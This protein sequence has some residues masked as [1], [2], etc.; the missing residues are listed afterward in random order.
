MGGI[1]KIYPLLPDQIKTF[2]QISNSKVS[3]F[4]V[5]SLDPLAVDNEQTTFVEPQKQVAAGYYY[6]AKLDTFYNKDNHE[7]AVWIND[8]Q[9]RRFVVVIVY[10]N[11]IIKVAG[12]LQQP[13]RL[14]ANPESG[15]TSKLNGVDISFSGKMLKRALF[16][17]SL[18]AIVAS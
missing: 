13:L 16:L 4:E 18:P 14:I 2:N 17:D 10:S 7:L 8:N 15:S 3:Q 11:G 9:N 5:Y 1:N 12:T 6:T